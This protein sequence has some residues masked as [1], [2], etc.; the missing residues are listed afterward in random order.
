M[1]RIKTNRN[2]LNLINWFEF[3]KIVCF[4]QFRSYEICLLNRIVQ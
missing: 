1:N 4:E 2:Q 3:N